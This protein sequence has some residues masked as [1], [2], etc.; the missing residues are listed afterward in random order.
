MLSETKLVRLEASV[1]RTLEEATKRLDYLRRILISTSADPARMPAGEWDDFLLEIAHEKQIEALALEAL[2]GGEDHQDRV[3]RM[4][5][6]IA[7]MLALRE[8]P[9]L[10]ELARRRSVH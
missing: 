6:F 1:R 8:I 5:D 4:I 9:E 2:R 10:Q 7:G 3:M